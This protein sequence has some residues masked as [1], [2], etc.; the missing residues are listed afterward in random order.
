M[1]TPPFRGVSLVPPPEQPC[2]EKGAGQGRSGL[3]P[4]TIKHLERKLCESPFMN[5]GDAAGNHERGTRSGSR[6]LPKASNAGQ[7]ASALC[8]KL[9]AWRNVSDVV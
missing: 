7:F 6:V 9:G 2:A 3:Q 1:G 8:A 5:G 4:P